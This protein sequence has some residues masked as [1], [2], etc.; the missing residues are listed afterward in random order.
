M[1]K[2]PQSLMA[3][4]TKMIAW[5]KWEFLRRNAEYL[6]D[7]EA[8]I[9][10]FGSWFEKHGYWYDRTIEAW[11]Q[12]LRFFEAVIAPKAK[13]ICRKMGNSGSFPLKGAC[14]MATRNRF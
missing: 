10:E 2:K 7:H 3:R 1:P 5:Y 14:K 9:R 4:E 6:K 13:A 11:G 8:F 12:N